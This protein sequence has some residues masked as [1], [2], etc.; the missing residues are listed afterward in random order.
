MW[1]E[2]LGARGGGGGAIN[3]NVREGYENI[4][5]EAYVIGALQ[6]INWP[7]GTRGHLHL[8]NLL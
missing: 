6:K 2:A 8:V 7:L 1:E 3:I 4:G 5:L